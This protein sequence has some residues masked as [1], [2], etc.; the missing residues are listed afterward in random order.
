VLVAELGAEPGAELRE[1]HRQILA[2]GPVLAGARPGPVVP[3]ELP[4]PVRQFTGRAAELAGLTAM[5]EQA[6]AQGP[7]T[8]V[9]SA[10]AGTA[11]V[12]KTALAMQW[13]HQ[14]ADRFPDGQLQVNLRGYD[15]GQPMSTADALAGFL[16]SL[17]MAERD[18]PAETQERAARYRSLLAGRRM[19]IMIDNAA[20]AERPGQ[21]LPGH[22]RRRAGAQSLAS[23]RRHPDL[24]PGHGRLTS[25]T[26]G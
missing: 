20:D 9:V 19:L 14:L 21:R 15:P 23:P 6:G 12:G 26:G 18:I 13:A 11:G 8:L 7:R 4:G 16:R 5:L 1:L 10:I 24:G 17:G 22:R 2:T 3:R 25:G